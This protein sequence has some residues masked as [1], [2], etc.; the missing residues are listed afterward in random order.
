[1]TGHVRTWV[2][3]GFFFQLLERLAANG[4]NVFISSD[5]GNTEALGIG[6]PQEGVLGDTRGQRCRIYSDALLRKGCLTVFP[7]SILWDN[8]GLPEGI[9]SLLAP[10]GKAFVQVGSTIVCH[11]GATLEEVCVPFVTI[12]AKS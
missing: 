12:A 2:E 5:H 6:T 9:S 3:E 10:Q 7:E 4:F 11:G 8:A 1:M